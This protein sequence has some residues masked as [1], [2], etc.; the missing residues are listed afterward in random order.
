VSFTNSIVFLIFVLLTLPDCLTFLC[1]MDLRMCVFDRQLLNLFYLPAG[2]SISSNGFDGRECTSGS[3]VDFDHD[4]SLE[5]RSHSYTFLGDVNS[6]AWGI[7]GDTYNQHKDTSFREF[8]FIS[9]SH[10]VT[11]HAFCEPNG[12]SE[13]ARTAPEGDFGQGRWVEWGP[14]ATLAPHMEVQEPSILCCEPPG[15]VVNVNTAN[16]TSE[17]PQNT[18]E[19]GDDLSRG[20]ASKKWLQSFFVKVETIKSDD[21]VWTRFPDKSSI[22]CSAEVVS[23]SLFNSNLPLLDFYYKGN[24]K[25]NKES[26][27]ETV[28]DSANYTF[29][30]SNS[31]S[32]VSNLK[33]DVLSN[34]FGSGV[35]DLY[36]C[37]RVFS[38]NSHHLIGFVLTL[39]DAVTVNTSNESE[40]SWSNNLLLVARLESWGIQWVS[41]VKLEESLNIGPV[42]EWADFRF[43]DNLLVCLSASGLIFLYAAI[44]GDYVACIDVLQTC[45]VN[46]QSAFLEKEKI[47]AGIHIKQVDEVREKSTYQLA[48]FSGR[49]MFKRLLV[50]S[51]TSLLAV[52]DEYGVIYVIHAGDYMP[53]KYYK[54]EKLLPHFQHLGL[55]MSVGSSDIGTQRVYSSYSGHLKSN[56]SS[57]MGGS[58]SFSDNIG[59]NVPRKIRDLNLQGKRTDQ[60]FHDSDVPS[61]SLRKIFLSTYRFNED[62]CISF[63]PLGITRFA[64]KHHMKNQKGSQIVHFDLHSELAVHDDS[65]LN[66]NEMFFLQ[67]RKEAFVGEAVGCTF[68]GCFYLVTEGGL[69][70]VLPSI[71]ISSNFLPVETIGYRQPII[72]RGIGCQVRDTLEINESKQRCPP[73]KLEVL[74]RVL[75]YES[76]EE[77]DRLCLE[78]GENN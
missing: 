32:P 75:L 65:C 1:H 63:S 4:F 3:V 41:S 5:S 14:S 11:V 47:S 24:S 10:G 19:V 29:I 77:A 16:G 59:T 66:G 12:G 31:A 76:P 35:N 67:G 20:V 36:K 71:S 39:V 9:G 37:S 58:L 73:W 56:M 17:I 68:G 42:V 34:V 40:R 25:S 61:H 26:W 15:N 46:P 49:R 64:R 70:V 54:S 53:D 48:G 69:S 74:D 51:H 60:R 27:Q 57:M 33:S 38:S 28:L 21:T 23:F 44:S 8:L 2:D 30:K 7:C 52:A 18:S 45:G 43:S 62:D 13:M 55:G 22:P 78:N 50:D 6:L 72:G